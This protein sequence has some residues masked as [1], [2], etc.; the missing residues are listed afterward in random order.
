MKYR[1]KEFNNR[2]TIEARCTSRHWL[3]I[4]KKTYYWVAVNNKGGS[5]IYSP[6]LG[7]FDTLEKARETLTTLRKG[8]II[9]NES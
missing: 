6:L 7:S 4:W 2:F 9:H 3:F 1:I 8:I 5:D